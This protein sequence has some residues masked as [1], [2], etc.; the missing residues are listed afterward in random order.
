[1]SNK[2]KKTTSK[3]SGNK[4]P[5][6]S[7]RGSDSYRMKQEKT[8]PIDWKAIARDERT[9][10]IVGAV[11]LLISLFLFTAF[12]SYF[13]TWNRDQD[14]VLKGS[15]ILLDNSVHVSNL[16]GKLGALVSHFFIFKAFG[17]ASLLICTFFF[18][19]GV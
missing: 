18:V 10:K 15:S 4:P 11:S 19:A 14:V 6:S 13:F 9:W 8:E 12:I 3:K 16:L 2:K 17:I 5:K 7:T 1:M